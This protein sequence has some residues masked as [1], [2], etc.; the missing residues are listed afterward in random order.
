MA[1][2]FIVAALVLAGVI[3]AL[4]VIGML[5]G[6][7]LQTL[8]EVS[9][10]DPS[11]LM[12]MRHRAVMLGLLGGLMLGSIAQP[13]WR[14]PSMV[15]VLLSMLSFVLLAQAEPALNQSV[16]KVMLIDAV[17]SLALLPALVLQWHSTAAPDPIP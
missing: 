1:A 11:L 4:P 6:E 9:I 14:L 5:S 8:Y 10:Q 7:R 12:L 13:A 16:R 3:N 17:V 15:A 2:K